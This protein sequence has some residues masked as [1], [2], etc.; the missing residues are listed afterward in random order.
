M[1]LYS[2]RHK[3]DAVDA[4][5]N[6]SYTDGSMR[7]SIKGIVVARRLPFLVEVIAFGRFPNFSSL[8]FFNTPLKK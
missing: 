3:N 4:M 1:L 8:V 2:D 5:L 7:S 6:F